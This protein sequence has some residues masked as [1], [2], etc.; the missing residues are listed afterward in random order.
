MVKERDRE[1]MENMRKRLECYNIILFYFQKTYPSISFKKLI[2]YKIPNRI[3]MGRKRLSFPSPSC[4][5]QWLAM[6]PSFDR[7]D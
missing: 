2:N 4:V 1:K 7:L 5:R 3:K 6:N